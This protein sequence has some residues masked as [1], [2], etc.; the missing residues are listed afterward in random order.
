[1]YETHFLQTLQTD[2]FQTYSS[3]QHYESGRD[4]AVTDFHL[5]H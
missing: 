3:N 1:M 4:I 2:V 5:A